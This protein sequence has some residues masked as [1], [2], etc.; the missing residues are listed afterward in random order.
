MSV[1]AFA[2]EFTTF[3]VEIEL[4]ADTPGDAVIK[5]NFSS[6]QAV[7]TIVLSVECFLSLSALCFQAFLRECTWLPSI[8][9]SAPCSLLISCCS[10]HA[11]RMLSAYCSQLLALSYIILGLSMSLSAQQHAISMLLSAGCSE[12]LGLVSAQHIALSMLLSISWFPS[13]ACS[14]LSVE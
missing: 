5:F 9:L 4:D 6:A 13:T 3:S 7:T 8:L 12:L 1:S 2:V 10:Q 14:Y 11:T